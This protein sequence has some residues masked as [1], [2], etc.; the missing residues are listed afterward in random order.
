[1][2]DVQERFGEATAPAVEP[3]EPLGPKA[4]P[5]DQWGYI[6]ED[7]RTEA[8]ERA[9]WLTFRGASVSEALITAMEGMDEQMQGL[10]PQPPWAMVRELA[11][12]W[13]SVW[14]DQYGHIKQRIVDAAGEIERCAR[15]E[16]LDPGTHPTLPVDRR[17]L[18][19]ELLRT[20]AQELFVERLA[21]I[22]AASA[23]PID[24]SEP[25]S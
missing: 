17:A 7:L 21:A 5:A 3:L 12:L 10:V 11:R 16:F 8:L 25:R 19:T 22:V 23:P 1:M 2:Q 13:P 6:P 20:R 18:P 4:L 14:R 15:E 9:A 24:E